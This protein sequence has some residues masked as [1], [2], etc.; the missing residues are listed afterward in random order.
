MRDAVMA[1]FQGEGIEVEAAEGGI[2]RV[3]FSGENGRFLC[4]VRADEDIGVFA[5]YSLAPIEVPPERM[6]LALELVARL[7]WG[8]ALGNLELDVDSGQ[9]RFKTSIDVENEV[10]TEGLVANAVYDNVASLDRVL[11]AITA[12]VVKGTPVPEALRAL[13]VA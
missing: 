8:H 3:A 5:F 6:A 11:P 10:L 12:V 7:N 9:L 4:F 1:F 13:E 2:L